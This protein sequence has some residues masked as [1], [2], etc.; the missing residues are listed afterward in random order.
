MDDLPSDID[1][2]GLR[3]W[4]APHPL[5]A[6]LITTRGNKN[7]SLGI[8]VPIDALQPNEAYALMTS[9]RKPDDKD[10]EEAAGA[11]AVDLLG[12]HALA[13]DLARGAME[14][15]RGVKT[16]HE[17]AENLRNPARDALEYAKELTGELPNG[18][19]KSIAATL[20]RSINLL[21]DE[22]KDF[23]LLASV[24]SSAPIPA[25]LGVSV[26]ALADGIEEEEAKERAARGMNQAEKLSLAAPVMDSQGSRR[27]HTLISRTMRFLSQHEE[28][29]ASLRQAAV[30]A[31]NAVLP[32]VAD[33][34][35]HLE[36]ED[37]VGHGRELSSSG[38][39]L[40]TMELLGWV[41]RYDDERG[42]YP[43]AKRLNSRQYESY[44]HLLGEDH[45]D[46]LNSM[47]NLAETLRAQG[48]LAGARRL[49]E[50][51]LHKRKSLLGEDHPA[52][53]ISAWNLFSTL[54]H[55]GDKE[56]AQKVRNDYL[57]WLLE[58][59]PD[60]LSADQRTIRGYVM[61]SMSNG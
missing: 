44:K 54:L 41:A 22:G 19:E 30:Q 25:K 53:T 61:D 45:P 51:G 47:N 21:N 7:D 59:D 11:I 4:L 43:S 24:L 13:V 38:I 20:L 14:A 5:G 56:S 3:K 16:F 39:D 50:E 29:R 36:L 31:L 18:H 40:E 33:I 42:A 1:A 37:W 9:G 48:D 34:R 6:T 23:L 32:Q 26:F 46:T 8:P 49:Q 17:F 10:E 15:Y 60:S 57:L 55:L 12:C 58:R 35:S 52:T 28:R 2:E 27:V